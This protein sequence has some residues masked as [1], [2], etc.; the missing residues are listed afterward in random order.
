MTLRHNNPVWEQAVALLQPM[1]APTLTRIAPEFTTR[2]FIDLLRGLPDGERAYQAAVR[3]WPES[4]EKAA[5]A[6]LH[7]QIVPGLLRASGQVEWAGY[8][9]GD[10]TEE[11]GLSVPARWQK[12]NDETTR[13]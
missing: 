2:G 1:I 5:R 7:G 3:L 6:T 10:P 12:I 13:T 11:D 9:Y 4:D 8:V